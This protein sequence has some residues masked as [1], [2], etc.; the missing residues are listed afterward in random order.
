MS[1]HAVTRRILRILCLPALLTIGACGAPETS[2]LGPAV[3]HTT[4]IDTLTE[5]DS[6][7]VAR[8]TRA[9]VAPDGHTYISDHVQRRVIVFDSS[10]RILR[11][12]GRSGEGPG[13]FI[14][15]TAI[16]LWGRDSLVVTDLTIGRISVF[17]RSDGEFLWHTVGLGSVNSLGA[18]GSRMVVAS[19]AF[20]SFTTVGV[21]DRGQRALRP[22]LPLPDSLRRQQLGFRA[23][24]RSIV[25]VSENRVVVGVLWS[26]A[27]SVYDSLLTELQ[28]FRVPRRHRRPIPVELDKAL[29]PLIN[30]T[31]RLTLIP[32]LMAI[33]PLRD[34]QIAFIH[35]D[36][37]AP[38]GGIS[39]PMRGVTEATLRAY[40]TIVDLEGRRACPDIELPA[41]WSEN[42]QFTSD[43]STLLGFGH[44][45]GESGR[46]TLE[47]RWY[48]LKLDSCVWE[49]LAISAQRLR[50]AF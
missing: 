47:R 21:I 32:A 27:V 44:V 45:I 38:P 36:W 35:K 20:D 12:I 43:G 50:Q 28:T 15:P 31:G 19:L 17:R 10:G 3:A 2:S 23:F 4:R 16:A 46:P 22:A 24:P 18:T 49:P 7:F 14:G 41:E 8:V 13:E 37:I 5:T 1:D 33:E 9:F 48:D 11:T 26:D 40:A 6:L 25:G 39:D 30:T 29:E 42:P 34:G